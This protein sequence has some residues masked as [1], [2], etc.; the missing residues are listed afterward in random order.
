MRRLRDLNEHAQRMGQQK[1]LGE[2]KK[3]HL[4]DPVELR[5]IRNNPEPPAGDVQ[6]RVS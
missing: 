5:R 1:S 6:Y 3:T 2:G 4:K